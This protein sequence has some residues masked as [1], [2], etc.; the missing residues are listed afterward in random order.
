MVNTPQ[1][2]D[3]ISLTGSF[4]RAE[5][6]ALASRA[7]PDDIADVDVEWTGPSGIA[8]AVGITLDR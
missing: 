1:F 2:D 8:E 6:D 7:L 4:T 5:A 3:T